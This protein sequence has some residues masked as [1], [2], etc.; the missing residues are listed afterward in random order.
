MIEVQCPRC[1]LYWYSDEEGG[2]VRLCAA[3]TEELQRHRRGSP[4]RVDAFLITTLALFLVNCVLIGLAA[5][6]PEVFGHFLLWYGVL[7]GVAG[8]VW[9]RLVHPEW[10]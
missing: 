6:L 9:F 10:G 1:N 7:L 5:A 2:H 8:G 3:C 4:V